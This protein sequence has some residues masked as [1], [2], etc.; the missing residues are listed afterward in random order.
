VMA[1]V[2]GR[3]WIEDLRIDTANHILGLRLNDWTCLIVFAGAASFFW[4]TRRRHAAAA[5]APD[6]EA[7]ASELASGGRA[8]SLS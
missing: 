3:F 8:G 1:Y 4:R 2:V 7:A 6:T 5:A